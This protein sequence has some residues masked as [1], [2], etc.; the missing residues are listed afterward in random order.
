MGKKK[1][2]KTGGNGQGST[3]VVAYLRVST[4]R[5][6]VDNQKLEILR[7][8]TERGLG[9]VEF[10]EETAS[11]RKSWRER[12]TF[13]LIES[14]QPG[15][16]LIVAELSRLGRSMLEIMEILSRAADRGLR[17]Y[18]AKGNWAL[19]DSLPSKIVASVLAMAAEIEKELISQRTKS[20]L[21]TRRAAGVVLGRPRGPG[22]SKLD[23]HEAEIRE[24]LA[25]GVPITRISAK[26]SSSVPNMRA[27]I[28]K[29]GIRQVLAEDSKT[30]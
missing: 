4:E 20:A 29:R 21:A 22:A 28:R 12:R 27:W 16:A 25:L 6:D 9:A 24:L 14:M 7:T 15:D 18:A 13:D 17:I 8:A 5:Q 26:M 19:D 2:Q 30:P 1:D 3:R 11:G 10:I 23:K